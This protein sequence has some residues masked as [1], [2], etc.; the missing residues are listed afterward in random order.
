[1]PGHIFSDL[2]RY[3]DAAWQQEASTGR[4][5]YMIRD[6]VLPNE[7]FNYAH[8]NEWL[9][10][11]LNMIGRVH[12]A[13]DLSKNMLDLPR[14]PKYNQPDRHGTSSDLGRVGSSIRWFNTSAGA[15]WPLYSLH[16]ICRR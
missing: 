5:A 8:N 11:D 9:I 6:G 16:P 2:H 12:D 15:I 1:M 10:R 14:H 7:I 3:A 4:P 13:I